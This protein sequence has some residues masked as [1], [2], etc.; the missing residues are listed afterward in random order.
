MLNI[1]FEG[2]KG[3]HNSKCLFRNSQNSMSQD[4]L[5][6]SKYN[7]TERTKQMEQILN[8][9][10]PDEGLELVILLHT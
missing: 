9:Q 2:I 5:P 3:Y 7:K 10:V 1:N 8:F 6:V 4:Y